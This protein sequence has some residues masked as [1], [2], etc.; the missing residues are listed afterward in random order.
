MR[1]AD[2]ELLYLDDVQVGQKFGSDRHAVDE[3][4]IRAFAAQFDPQPFHLDEQAAFNSLFGGLATSG[5]HTASITMRLLVT[6]GAPVVG[7]RRG[8]T[9][10]LSVS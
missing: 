7:A 3:P 8:S 6:G 1:K 2:D 5:W 9:S 4:Q 10:R